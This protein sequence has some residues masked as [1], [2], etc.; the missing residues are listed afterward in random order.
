MGVEQEIPKVDFNKSK[1]LGIEVMNFAELLE[2][3]QRSKDHDPFS[4]HKIE[5]F[6]ILIITKGSYSHFVD[7][8]F[9][10]VHKGS[11]L[12]VAKNQVH[13]FTDELLQAEG[14]GIIFSSDFVDKHYFLA[15]KFKLNR[16]FNY[17]IET[18]LVEQKQVG[19][20]AFIDLAEELHAEQSIANPFAKSEMLGSLLNVLLLKAERAKDLESAPLVKTHW[21][22]IFN[23]FKN[24]VE[25]EYAN[26]RNSR[27]YASRLAISYKFLNDVV[28]KLSG[29][30]A[31]A[32]ID[33]FVTTEIK[34][35]LVTTSLSVKEISHK[36]G[37]D[38][39][40]NMTKFFKK[41]VATTPLN[42]R[43][44]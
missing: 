16:L 3:L 30:T 23:S 9:Y 29:K 35:Y 19:N 37:F 5:F 22:E 25:Q 31:K 10:E 28:K 18:P 20:N 40:G 21:L 11:A 27:E 33:D 44:Q 17:H 12:F 42:F 8:N 24:L 1:T 41:H 13:H 2:S 32:F 34:R 36:T 15:D 38:E 6:L 4:V 7:F 26:T 39:P 14:F 43:Q